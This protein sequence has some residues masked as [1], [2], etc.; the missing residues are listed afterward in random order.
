[1]VEGSTGAGCVL[2]ADLDA[3]AKLPGRRRRLHRNEGRM[4]GSEDSRGEEAPNRPRRRERTRPFFLLGAV[5]DELRPGQLCAFV[6]RRVVELISFFFFSHFI[7][8][9]CRHH[10]RPTP[11]PL[12]PPLPPLL[13]L[14][15]A[16][17]LHRSFCPLPLRLLPFSCPSPPH[18]LISSSLS[19]THLV[20][21]QL[22]H[23]VWTLCCP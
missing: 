15:H 16:P 4:K 22:H 13:P 9:T 17:S 21:P 11:P 7:N 14:L 12:P 2:V 19:H 1:M 10:P 8:S 18:L 20:S 23:L 3:D 5:V 6:D